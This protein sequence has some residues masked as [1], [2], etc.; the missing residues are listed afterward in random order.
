[1]LEIYSY[2]LSNNRILKLHEPEQFNFHASKPKRGLTPTYF[3][4]NKLASQNNTYSL[5]R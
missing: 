5:V 2:E 3:E 1:M 4:E